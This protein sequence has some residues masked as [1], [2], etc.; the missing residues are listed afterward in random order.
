MARTH[1]GDKLTEEHRQHQVRLVEQLAELVRG[2]FRKH[3]DY[4]DI[5]GSTDA[6]ARSAGVLVDQFREASRL[7]SIDYMREFQAV[8]APDAPD[9]VEEPSEYTPAEAA[10]SLLRTS[11]GV[12]KTLSRKGYSESE[13]MERAEQAVVGKATKIAGDG[14]RQVIEHE[15]RRGNGPLGYARVVDADPCPFC[16]ML[17]SRGV[18]YA[19]EEQAG[20]LLYRSDSF[21]DSNARFAGDGRFKVHDHCC[22]TLEPVYMVDGK[23]NL[24]GNGNEL[25][26]EWAEIA[27]GQE[28]PWLAWQRWRQSGTLPEN[29]DGP[30]EGVR[31][32]KPPVRGQSS[33]RRARPEPMKASERA[34][35]AEQKALEKAG[36][37]PVDRRGNWDKRKY[38]D[39]ADELEIRANGVASEIAAL[40]SVG[41]GDRD[42]P[43]MQLKQQHR[44][45]LS[46][47]DRYRK[48]GMSM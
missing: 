38:L 43:V 21:R 34:E 17:A 13:A 32:R 7:R 25:A 1:A 10:E 3:V 20:A 12:L 24:P 19:G 26:R 30:L 40:K 33:G 8:E 47:I 9:V 29:Y 48:T 15:V 45:L 16:A 41:Q 37:K 35:R 22:C 31:R 44:A 23:V 2:L 18:Y 6:F 46:R 4:A 36:K 39:Y 42:L 27:S 14:G 5:D 28:D 11:R